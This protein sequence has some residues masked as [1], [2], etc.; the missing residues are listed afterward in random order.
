MHSSSK[1]LAAQVA[2]SKIYYLEE[3]TDR[4]IH[5]TLCCCGVL[6][7]LPHRAV[8]ASLYELDGP[9]LQALYALLLGEDEDSFRDWCNAQESQATSYG[10]DEEAAI[11]EALRQARQDGWLVINYPE[12][13]PW[14]YP[15]LGALR[16]VVGNGEPD[17]GYLAQEVCE[18]DQTHT[19]NETVCGVCYARCVSHI[20]H[21]Y[22]FSTTGA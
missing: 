14:I 5:D 18:C 9:G 1:T 10:L 3:D 13:Y 15:L 11:Q 21:F 7:D 8:G 22:I 12:V 4:D 19:E 6:S 17:D 2:A 16:E 20:F